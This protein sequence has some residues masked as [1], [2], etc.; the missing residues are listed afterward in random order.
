MEILK[1]IEDEIF[2]FLEKEMHTG[3]K[4]LVYEAGSPIKNEKD[5]MCFTT[6]F[7]AS[8]YAHDNTSNFDTMLAKPIAEIMSGIQQE[9]F[10]QAI[11][12]ALNSF[13]SDNIESILVELQ[14][15]GFNSAE[16]ENTL[17]RNFA[18]FEYDIPYE[19]VLNNSPV[20]FYIQL[21]KDDD[22]ILH[23]SG[24][25]GIVLPEQPKIQH[26]VYNHIDTA[27]LDVEM[28]KIDWKNHSG[29]FYYRPEDRYDPAK[30]EM[31]YLEKKLDQLVDCTWQT[32]KEIRDQAMNVW[33]ALM[34]KHFTN[35]P[36]MTALI[37]TVPYLEAIF[38]KRISFKKEVPL[39]EAAQVLQDLN[40]K[41][42]ITSQNNKIMNPQNLEFLQSSLKYFGF[43]DKLNHALENNI[44]EQ[45]AEFQIKHEIPHFNNKMD[46]TLHFKKSENS[47]MYFFNR[48]DAALKNGK[49]ENDKLQSFYVNK[50]SGITA[51]EAFN[52]LEG[53]A[54]FKELINKEGE[55]YKAWVKIDFANADNK[56][57]HLLKHFNEK[58]GFNL[59]RTLSNYPVNELNIPEQKS[60]LLSSLEKGNAQQ[61]TISKDGKD[62][63][64]YIEAVPQFKNINIYD[65]KMHLV[66]R[67]NLQ[68]NNINGHSAKAEKPSMK[69]GIKKDADD[70]PAKKR[71]TRKR[72]HSI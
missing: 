36:A 70:Q 33:E 11:Q 16:L 49:P 56:G 43:G 24:Y 68:A 17:S 7:D 52:L 12:H 37:A 22:G 14:N 55:K 60:K 1:G 28:S 72:A 44:K 15:T 32:S 10:E 5:F 2:L 6:E 50:G 63:K 29:N 51:K 40:N 47:D 57:N 18:S 71:Q 23:Y 20:K 54:V 53:R 13:T 46:F 27:A 65:S 69:V 19:T 26:G 66:R 59:E 21:S 61:V 38:E 35:T 4:W 58:Y 9:L 42:K 39:S 31:Y 30:R 3:K 45:K 62:A 64:Y 25:D 67:E 41:N 34:A 48:Y 8:Q